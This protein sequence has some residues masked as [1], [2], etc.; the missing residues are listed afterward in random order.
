MMDAILDRKCDGSLRQSFTEEVVG[1][2]SDALRRAHNEAIDTA[3]AT[4]RGIALTS[5]EPPM[6]QEAAFETCR[7]IVLGVV[8]ALK[9]SP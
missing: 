1:E 8:G 2:M 7:Q 6:S 4:V 5:I 9:V 3:M